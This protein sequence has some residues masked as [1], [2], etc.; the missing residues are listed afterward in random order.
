MKWKC[1]LRFALLAV[2][3]F[4]IA[5]TPN[6]NIQACAAEKE[7]NSAHAIL[8]DVYQDGKIDGKDI[9]L[10][11]QYRLHKHELTEEQVAVGDV[12]RDGKI[13]GKDISK[14]LQYRLGKIDDLGNSQL[15]SVNPT[16]EPADNLKKEYKLSGTVKTKNGT[17]ATRYKLRFDLKNEFDNNDLR[18]SHEA[19]IDM[20]TGG[21][22]VSLQPGEY[23]ISSFGEIALPYTDAT[24]T[25]IDPS[26]H[27]SYQDFVNG[28]V[29]VGEQDQTV[30]F[31][32]DGYCFSG[33][34]TRGGNQTYQ[35]NFRSSAYV[36][37]VADTLTWNHC[38]C[39]DE[40][41]YFEI[42]ARTEDM[43]YAW[44]NDMWNEAKHMIEL[45]YKNGMWFDQYQCQ[46]E[47]NNQDI[48][49]LKFASDLYKI[50]GKITNRGEGWT[51]DV[52]PYLMQYDEQ[53]ESF[54]AIGSNMLDI[55]YHEA[56]GLLEYE[57][58]VSPGIYC[59]G[60]DDAKSKTVIRVENKDQ[61][62]LNIDFDAYQLKCSLIHDG[63]SG[64]VW[65]NNEESGHG[66]IILSDTVDEM[67]FGNDGDP[68]YINRGVYDVKIY[69]YEEGNTEKSSWK[70]I[71]TLSITDH[72]LDAEI[73]Y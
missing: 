66:A 71:G 46:F 2:L 11:L 21:Y 67:W 25:T 44:N 27:Y 13:D 53:S 48:S 68:K 18:M 34:I 17:P 42:F 63:S 10:L 40:N 55:K 29:I 6:L 49:N 35:D 8:G 56:S 73:R 60:V 41:G 24:E 72:D 23:V 61:E 15:P 22:E 37:G 57:C 33:T 39:L 28:E 50:T 69:V 26:S 38:F 32:F 3:M 62:D 43:K 19:Q 59:L 16:Q 65:N 14:L 36:S 1:G 70:S 9:S 5:Y 12:Y 64:Y 51:S 20:E 52:M 4:G 7:A 54:G 47:F 58:Y 30:D 31:I 45:Q